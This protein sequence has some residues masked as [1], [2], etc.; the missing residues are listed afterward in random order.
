MDNI[1]DWLYIIF[2]IIAAIS[3]MRSSNKNKKKRQG[4]E[5]VIRPPKNKKRST[6][7]EVTLD[8]PETARV[9]PQAEPVLSSADPTTIPEPPVFEEG[10]RI[11]RDD[12][13]AGETVMNVTGTPQKR[14]ATT[15]NPLSDPDELKKAIIYAEILNR[16]Y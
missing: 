12:D 11:V 16:K 10:K 3:G 4:Q 6:P 15:C 7:Q 8:E 5:E 13:L 14:Q 9:I 2:L 1:G